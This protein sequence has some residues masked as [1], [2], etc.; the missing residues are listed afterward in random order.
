[1]L[2]TVGVG[3]YFG[4]LVLDGGPR[5][6]FDH[7]SRAVPLFRDPRGDIEDWL[8][9]NPGV[10]RHLDPHADRQGAQPHQK[11]LDLALKDVYGPVRPSHRRERDRAKGHAP[12]AERLTQHDI[13]RAN[14][15]LARDGDRIVKDSRGRLHFGRRQADYG[16]QE[17]PFAL[18]RRGAPAGIGSRRRPAAEMCICTKPLCQATARAD[19]RK[20]KVVSIERAIP[21]AGNQTRRPP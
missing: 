5:F 14:R 16:S 11:V 4:E 8:D 1:V 21:P 17:T 15:R 3:D 10:R 9:R 6:R 12:G 19:E 18:V 7:D 2:S 13:G 20:P